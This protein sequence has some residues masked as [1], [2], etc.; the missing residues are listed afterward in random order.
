MH[1]N[2]N[3]LLLKGAKMTHMSLLIIPSGA[4]VLHLTPELCC[5]AY[6]AYLVKYNYHAKQ[7]MDGGCVCLL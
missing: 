2:A 3:E 5:N 4:Q 6:V 1:L 7:N